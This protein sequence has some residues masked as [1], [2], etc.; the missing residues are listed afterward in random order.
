GNPI[1]DGGVDGGMMYSMTLDFCYSIAELEAVLSSSA[2]PQFNGLVIAQVYGQ[3]AFGNGEYGRDLT[4]TVSG[5]EI[6]YRTTATRL[7][8][9]PITLW[10][11]GLVGFKVINVTDGGV[12]QFPPANMWLAERIKPTR[13]LSSIGTCTLKPGANAFLNGWGWPADDTIP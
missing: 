12:T 1:T 5:S 8:G 10:L 6:C 4:G 7:P 11:D 2:N 13:C 9:F 3:V